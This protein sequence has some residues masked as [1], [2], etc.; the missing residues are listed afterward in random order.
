MVLFESS[1]FK[2]PVK[3]IYFSSWKSLDFENSAQRHSTTEKS[4]LIIQYKIHFLT[5]RTH[6]FNSL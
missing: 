5:S 6:N 2:V 1:K 4:M 3:I